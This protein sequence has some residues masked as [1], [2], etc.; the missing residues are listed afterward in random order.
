MMDGKLTKKK[1]FAF[2]LTHVIGDSKNFY[3]L[4]KENF[5]VCFI[6]YILG[7]LQVG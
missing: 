6:D 7:F 1:C 4:R 2:L 3:R 5:K